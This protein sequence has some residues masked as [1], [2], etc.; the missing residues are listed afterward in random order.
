LEDL[1]AGWQISGRAVAMFEG[2][3]FCLTPLVFRFPMKLTEVRPM[4]ALRH[5][6]VGTRK[7]GYARNRVAKSFH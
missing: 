4:M 5:F 7:G 6:A 2:L 3:D 1:D